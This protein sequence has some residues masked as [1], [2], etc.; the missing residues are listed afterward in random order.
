MAPNALESSH[1]LRLPAV[2]VQP[3]FLPVN[4]HVVVAVVLAQH[5]HKELGRAW[6]PQLLKRLP[7]LPNIHHVVTIGIHLLRHMDALQ[8][9]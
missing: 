8:M 6:Q 4:H 3:E 1:D 9:A 7:Q 2:Y 5:G